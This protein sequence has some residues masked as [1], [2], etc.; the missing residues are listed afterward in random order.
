[1]MYG[2]NSLGMGY[3][4][5]VDW[6]IGLIILIIIIWVVVKVVT[7]KHK[8]N[9]PGNITPLDILKSRYAKGEISKAEFEEKKRDVK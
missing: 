6:L 1:M 8:R 2:N 5:W 3:G 4:N 7:H 9:L